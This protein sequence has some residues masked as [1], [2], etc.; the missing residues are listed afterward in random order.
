MISADTTPATKAED[1]RHAAR[2]AGTNFLAVIGGIALGAFTLVA[3]RLYGAEIYGLFA[4]G[5]AVADLL[6]RGGTLGTDRGLLRYIPAHTIAGE[7]AMLRAALRT[8]FFATIAGGIVLAGA[9]WLAAPLLAAIQ[10]RPDAATAIRVIAPSGLFLALTVTLVSA[11][12]GA[13]I[14]RYNFLVRGLTYPLLLLALGT[15]AALVDPTLASL[16]TAY[17]ATTAVVALLAAIAAARVFRALPLRR[18]LFRR[19]ASEPAVHGRMLRFSLTLGL[20]DFLN[21]IVQRA[22][23]VVMGFFVSGRQLGAYAAASA[24]CGLV[25]MPRYAFDP[26]ASPVLAEA[27]HRNDRERLRYNLALMTRWVM[28][29]TF[30][31]VIFIGALWRNLPLVF[32]DDFATTVPIVLVFLL[33]QTI[34]GM[35]GLNGWVVAMG[36]H[37]RLLLVD[38][39]VAAAMNIGLALVLAP[40]IGIL[41]GAIASVVAVTTL[42]T[43]QL[44]QVVWIHRIHPF[45]RELAKVFAAGVVALVAASFA[46][47]VVPDSPGLQIGAG[48]FFALVVF[49]ALLLIA[50]LA[51]EERDILAGVGRRIRAIARAEERS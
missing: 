33:G 43:A 15:V 29:V 30:P 27:L 17:L 21:A 5:V 18:A 2:G 20:T 37:G 47:A 45:S 44:L 34:N 22:D 11:T 3:T 7:T 32:G 36:G 10:N 28:L 41:G 6:A 4:V 51:D 19:D 46:M 35:M 25:S 50:G 40:R 39:C 38:N 49:G 26:V 42:Q 31:I 13:K 14:L 12:M 48:A 1:A 9:A 24:L 16:C 8:A 23:L